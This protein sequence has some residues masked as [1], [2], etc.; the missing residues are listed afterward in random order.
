[1]VDKNFELKIAHIHGWLIGLGQ[2]CYGINYVPHY[3][4]MMFTPS[5]NEITTDILKA[6]SSRASDRLSE[7]YECNDIELIKSWEEYLSDSI[8]RWVF[9]RILGD[10]QNITINSPIPNHL[11]YLH[12]NTANRLVWLIREAMTSMELD[13]WKFK[14]CHGYCFQ[15]GFDNEAYAFKSVDRGLIVTFGWVD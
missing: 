5:S 1:M 6:I 8:D 11:S 10:R 4:A 9:Q 14:I 7:R 13:V 3:N 2:L 12:K 15:Y